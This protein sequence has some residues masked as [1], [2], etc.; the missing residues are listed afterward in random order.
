MNSLILTRARDSTLE[1]DVYTRAPR[2]KVLGSR[3]SPPS[4]HSLRDDELVLDVFGRDKTLTC[5]S[6]GCRK[7][8]LSGSYTHLN[9]LDDVHVECVARPKKGFTNA[10]LYPMSEC[11]G[12]LT[13]FRFLRPLYSRALCHVFACVEMSRSLNEV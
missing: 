12:L 5:S 13:M 1:G 2:I 10:V 11:P 4:L 7:S 6:P 8:L 9:C 3:P